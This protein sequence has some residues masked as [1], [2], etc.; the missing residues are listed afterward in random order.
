MKK[1]IKIIDEEIETDISKF[2]EWFIKEI[3]TDFNNSNYF[4]NEIMHSDEEKNSFVEKIYNYN[5]SIWNLSIVLSKEKLLDIVNIL[6]SQDFNKNNML[7]KTKQIITVIKKDS[8]NLSAAD[9]DVSNGEYI[10]DEKTTIIIGTNN[11]LNTNEI[12]STQL[13]PSIIIKI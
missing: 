7:I 2:E 1:N 4:L 12:K 5:K 8:I 10:K 3:K 9:F 6:F 13:M 11:D